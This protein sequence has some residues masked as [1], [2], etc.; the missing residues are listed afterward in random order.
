M[1]GG[2]L[3]TR[4]SH[5]VII[6]LLGGFALSIPYGSRI[7][8]P[9]F[10]SILL[11]V[12]IHIFTAYVALRIL[13]A[14]EHYPRAK[15]HLVK[16]RKKY[17]PGAKFII[18]KA[19]KLGLGGGLTICTFLFGWEPT[20]AIAY[21]LNVNATTTMKTIILGALMGASF[22]YAAYEGLLKAFPSQIVAILLI[23]GIFGIIG[24]V[25]RQVVKKSE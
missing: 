14:I 2:V 21:L 13:L 17:E 7:G 25:I 3:R 24:L 15:P 9:S 5:F 19:G 18:K 12:P 10:L 22:F 8:L 4:I 6:S 1:I 16:L 11:V 20:I 23:L